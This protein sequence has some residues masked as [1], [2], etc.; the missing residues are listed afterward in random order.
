MRKSQPGKWKG[1]GRKLYEETHK[2]QNVKKAQRKE[3]LQLPPE[4][5]VSV[6]IS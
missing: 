4:S 1:L 6:L 3:R 2:F 5:E